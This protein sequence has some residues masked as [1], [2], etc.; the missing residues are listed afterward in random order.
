MKDQLGVE[1]YMKPVS[2]AIKRHL[3]WPSDE[4]TEIYNRAFE[5]VANAI[6]AGRPG[7][8]PQIFEFNEETAWILGQPNFMCTGTA[9]YLRAEGQEIPRKTEAEQAAVIYWMLVL[10]DE[11]GKD[12]REFG[13]RKMREHIEKVKA[14]QEEE[15]VSD[16]ADKT[17]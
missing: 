15:E 3:Q 2:D 4:F 6:T 10:Y 9:E 16:E 17:D 14:K 1:Q 7:G 11:H 13:A 8:D 12:W 5:A